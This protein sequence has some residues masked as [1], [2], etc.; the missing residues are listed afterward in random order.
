MTLDGRNYLFESESLFGNQSWLNYSF[1]GVTF[2]FHLW[3]GVDGPDVG[4]VCGNATEGDGA[5]YDYNFSDGPT[6]MTNPPWQ[7]WV[8]PD[9]QV[10]VQYREGGMVHLLVA[11]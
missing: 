6:P 9:Y 7:T 11:A 5:V 4:I 8:A 1:D 3:C 2:G 10:A